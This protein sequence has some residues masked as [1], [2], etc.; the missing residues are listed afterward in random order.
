MRLRVEE[1]EEQERCLI[2]DL[3]RHALL[4]VAGE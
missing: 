1:E 4:A 2:K 3:Q